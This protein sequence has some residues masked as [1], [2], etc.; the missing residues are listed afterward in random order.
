[1]N[2]RGSHFK[3]QKAFTDTVVANQKVNHAEYQGPQLDTIF[4]H[5]D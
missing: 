3:K 4:T 2:F 5:S 1:M